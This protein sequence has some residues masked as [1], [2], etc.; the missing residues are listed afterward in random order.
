M[1]NRFLS[2]F[3]LKQL[4]SLQAGF[5]LIFILPASTNY[6]LKDF[7]FG[8]GGVGDATS[9]NYA[10]DAVSGEQSVGRIKSASYGIGSGLIFTNQSNVP[11]A[12]ILTNPNNYYNKLKIVIDNG[13]NPSDTKFS[14]AI[15]TDNFVSDIRY[16]QSDNTVGLVRGIEDYATYTAW[17]GASGSFIIGLMPNTAY[18]VKVNAW[19]GKFTETGFGPFSTA[20]T[21]SPQMTFDIDVAATDIDNNVTATTFGDLFAGI[22]TNSQ[23]KIWVDFDTNA[24]NGGKI[25]VASTYAGLQ[26]T[27]AS[28]TINSVSGNLAVLPEGYGAQGSSATQ[29]AGGPFS[30]NASYN[31]ASDN[32]A[33]TDGT[34]R[35]IFST[36]TP[37][38]LGRGSFSLKA[39]SSNVTPSANDYTEILTIIASASF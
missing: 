4:F 38:S 11:N 6:Q 12:P 25:Y 2:S 24:E 22:V 28:Y 14:I 33:V 26:S 39:K 36:G 17:G 30:L 35:E 23:E 7:S 32:V 3:F 8:S 34:L 18:Q 5:F 13:G 15:S 19:Q 16:V 37:T 10:L 29:S 21:V 27:S 1:K 31:L 9:G 20:S